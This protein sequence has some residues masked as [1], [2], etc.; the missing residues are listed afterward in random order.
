VELNGWG[1]QQDMEKDKGEKSGQDI[2]NEKDIYIC[3]FKD[4]R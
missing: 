3:N 4:R 2:L 1:A